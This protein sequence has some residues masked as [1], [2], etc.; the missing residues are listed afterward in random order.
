M[1]CHAPPV[2]GPYPRP[3]EAMGR[4]A[5]VALGVGGG[6]AVAAMRRRTVARLQPSWAAMARWLRP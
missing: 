5:A 3:G 2:A 1:R 6:Q 4:W